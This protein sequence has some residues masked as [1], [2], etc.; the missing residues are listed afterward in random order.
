[1]V[2][3]TSEGS[4][5]PPE[6]VSFLGQPGGR[7]VIIKGGAGTGK[8]TLG[9]EILEKLGMEERSF[10]LST[11]VS[12]DALLRQFPWLKTVESRNR[13]YDAGKIF[14]ESLAQGEREGTPPASPQAR[15]KVAQARS[16]LRSLGE[17]STRPRHVDRTQ[18]GSLLQRSRMPELEH[19]YERI[20]RVL[21]EKALLVV[22]SLEGVTHK[23]GLEMEELVMALQKDLAE[24]SNTNVVMVLEKPEAGGIEYLVDGLVSLSREE[25]D[26]RRIRH[27]RLE[28]L[29]ATA[30]PRPR[31]ALTLAGGR[32]RALGLGA[33]ARRDALAPPSRPWTPLR[34]SPTHFSTGIPDFDALLGG[35]FRRG[36]Y[37]GFELDVNVSI[38]DYYRLF[39]PVFLNFLAQGR[40]ILGVLS[41]GE[42]PESLRE[43]LIRYVPAR[44]FDDRVRITDY[45]AAEPKAP[46]ILPM[47]RAGRE[48]AQ[49][50]LQSAERAVR[51]E[52]DPQPYLEYTGFDTLE[53]LQGDQLAIRTLFMGVERTNLM[54]DVGLGLL[55]PGLSSTAEIVNMME[56]YFRLVSIDN[57][58]CLYGVRPRTMLYAIVEDPEKGPPQV[59]LIPMV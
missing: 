38:E 23:Y 32:F 53:Y 29:R 43:Q 59:R 17:E 5:I 15:E 50:A 42:A 37:N 14:L 48:D 18:L 22:D 4:G 34:D 35:G 31:Y 54:G 7:S 24:N 9:L 21:P 49:R 57:T 46:Y 55:K 45:F 51:G 36:S 40:G 27:L 39:A 3:A 56:T 30:I 2:L 6:L 12:D 33:L 16:L 13:L 10:Y 8:T 28:K 41:G 11:R 44:I 1:M 47:L 25:V 19:M 58:P 20:E 52:E 26:E